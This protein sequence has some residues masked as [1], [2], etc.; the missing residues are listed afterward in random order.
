M[1]KI[2]IKNLVNSKRTVNVSLICDPAP[3]LRR[4]GEDDEGA[5]QSESVRVAYRAMS[6]RLSRELGNEDLD[7]KGLCEQLARIVVSLPDIVG[8]DEKPIEPTVDFF[9]SLD[10]EN[11][12]AI[13]KAIGED[14][15]PPTKP[16]NS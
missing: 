13:N 16:S 9:D 10:I 15:N 1:S 11:L 4:A 5:R 2:R 7:K 14:I 12:R 3:G 6:L 8:D